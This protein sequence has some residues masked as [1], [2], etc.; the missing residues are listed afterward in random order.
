MKKTILIIA[1]IATS[2]SASAQ[3]FPEAGTS[4]LGFNVTGLSNVMFG[5]FGSTALSGAEISDP[6]FVLGGYPL[7]L[8]NLIPQNTL[9]YKR[10]YDNNLASRFTLGINSI[11]NKTFMGDSTG[12]P[13]EY[14]ETEEK[15]SGLT[16]GIGAGLEKHM[17]TSASKVDPFLGA[18]IMFAMFTGVDYSSTSDVTGD[19]YS[20]SFTQDVVYPGG[21]GFALNLLGGFNYFFSDYIS[22]G[23]EVGLGFG[24]MNSGGEWTSD[25]EYSFTS[26]GT[27]TTTLTSDRGE[28]KN[29]VSGINVNSYGGV[30]LIV[31]W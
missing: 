15:V 22:I 14:S 23:G 17:E 6:A 4:G 10:Y 25:S 9:M 29:S 31:Y 19:G 20:S 11:S 16:F 5:N 21:I 28:Y 13:L 2:L 3:N 24:M 30:N 26:G 27:T 12:L 7:T 18:E 8:N 1:V